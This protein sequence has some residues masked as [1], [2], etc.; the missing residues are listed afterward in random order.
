VEEYCKVCTEIK[1]KRD[2]EKAERIGKSAKWFILIWVAAVIL[3]FISKYI[4]GA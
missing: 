3:L 2:A 4:R 1:T